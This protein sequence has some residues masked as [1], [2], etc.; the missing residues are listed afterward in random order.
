MEVD[1]SSD[2]E[3]RLLDEIELWFLQTKAIST[4]EQPLIGDPMKDLEDYMY[5]WERSMTLE[6]YSKWRHECFFSPLS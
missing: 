2:A 5:A 3:S 6:D 4:H 1:V